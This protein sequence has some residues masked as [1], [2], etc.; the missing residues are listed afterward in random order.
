MR[1]KPVKSCQEQVDVRSANLQTKVL[2][3]KLD[4]TN[5]LKGYNLYEFN[6]K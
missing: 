1:V 3:L 4:G 6:R 5:H 2:Y